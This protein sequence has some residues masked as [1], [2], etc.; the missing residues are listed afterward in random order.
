MRIIIYGAGGAGCVIGGHLAQTG[1]DVVLIGRPGHV[2]KINDKSES[3][4]SKRWRGNFTPGAS[5]RAHY[6]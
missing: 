2:N 3:R 1:Y 5:W 6:G 4:V